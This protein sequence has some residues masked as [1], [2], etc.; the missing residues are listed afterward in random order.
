MTDAVLIFTFSPVQSFIAEARRAADLYVG[1]RI[2]SELAKAAAQAIGAVNLV[3]PASL[4]GSVPNVIVARVPAVEAKQIAE[5]AEQ[6]LRKTWSEISQTA[7]N[8][9]A[10]W[11]FTDSVFDAIWK[12]QANHLWE[13]FWAAAE[14]ETSGYRD[15]YERA[16]A[17]LD[18]VKRSRLFAACDEPGIKDTLSGRREALHQHG[19]T[20]FAQVKGFWAQVGK[21]T[22]AAKLRPDGRERLDAIGAT[23]RFCDLAS[24]QFPSTSTIAALDFIEHAK[25]VAAEALHTYRDVVAPL[26]V[27]RVCDDD[28]W[29]YDGDLLFEETL[30]PERL[31]DSY[32]IHQP[33]KQAL[34]KACQA[35]KALHNAA[36]GAPSPYYAVLVLDGDSMGKRISACLGQDDPKGAHA[37]LSQSLDAFAQQVQSIVP[38]DCLIY[39]GGDDVLAFLPLSWALDTAHK[40]AQA[41]EQVA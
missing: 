15:A 19:Q 38:K 24:Q 20:H 22:T 1:S 32:G 31:K 18:A 7:H 26:G 28:D 10:A 41:F 14:E 36:G 39:N 6:A 23:K 9:F 33:D 35:L 34:E 17:A 2:L 37:K 8:Q 13:V 40:L 30:T 27:Y 11:K 21:R 16:R 5:R 3:Y 29:P 12:R 25:Q 4:N